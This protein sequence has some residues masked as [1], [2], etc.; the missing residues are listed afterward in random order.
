MSD[1]GAFLAAYG[2]AT[3]S[4]CRR[5]LAKEALGLTRSGRYRCKDEPDCRLAKAVAKGHAQ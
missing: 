5:I 1:E 4:V 3:C 2:L